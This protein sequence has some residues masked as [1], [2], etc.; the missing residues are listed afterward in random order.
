MPFLVMQLSAMFMDLQNV[1]K[2]ISLQMTNLCT[3]F[4]NKLQNLDKLLTAVKNQQKCFNQGNSSILSGI[5]QNL[6][7]LKSN[8]ENNTV[9]I[10]TH[11]QSI[12]DKIQYV[13]DP[14]RNSHHK[15]KDVINDTNFI[16]TTFIN[17]SKVTSSPI[18]SNQS[19]PNPEQENKSKLIL[20][21]GS[22]VLKGINPSRLKNNIRVKHFHKAT[23]HALTDQLINME[24]SVYDTGFFILMMSSNLSIC[25]SIVSDSLSVA[26]WLTVSRLFVNFNTPC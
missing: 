15:D 8:V 24:M 26:T 13:P 17:K 19:N 25:T 18:R 11:S 22:C 10:N 1:T 12:L 9:P 4:N 3:S 16:N 21:T 14:N 5:N 6:S 20:I 7:N 2:E 23:R